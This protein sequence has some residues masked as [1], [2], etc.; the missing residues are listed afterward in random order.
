MAIPTIRSEGDLE[1]VLLHEV[2][3]ALARIIGPDLY[4][5]GGTPPEQT[6][7]F[8]NPS[9]FNLF[10]ILIVEF[11]AEGR[12]SVYIDQ[13]FQNLSLLSGLQWFCSKY[14]EETSSSGLFSEVDKIDEWVNR[15]MPIKFWCSGVDKDVEFRITNREL[16]I[17]S[18]NTAKHHLLRLS[19]L[20]G[21]L[22]TLTSSVGY[23]FSPQELSA[24]LDALIVEVR[25]RLE[26]HSTFILELFGDLFLSVNTLIVGRFTANPTNRVVDMDMPDGVSS[27]VFRDLYGSVLV[28]LRYEKERILAFTPR[29][30]R[31]L[32]MRYQ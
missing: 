3:S 27:D 4:S 16:I 5:I 6:A 31:Y 26:Y 19:G 22:E 13:K 8:Q 29:T 21:K 1:V 7:L 25:S 12:K 23:S 28:F 30:T 32:K 2:H 20:L 24:V 11:F 10:L 18:A 15:K 14:P 17:F 9:C